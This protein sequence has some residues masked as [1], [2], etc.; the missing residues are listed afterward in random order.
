[1][2]KSIWTF[3][4]VFV[5]SVAARAQV[6]S[7]EEP[8]INI[9]N[10]LRMTD[11]AKQANIP[12]VIG[13]PYLFD[14]WNE[15]EMTTIGGAIIRDILL[16]YNCYSGQ[17][18]VIKKS[19]P[20]SLLVNQQFIREFRIFTDS[21]SPIIF[22][23]YQI[24]SVNNIE[25]FAFYEVLYEGGVNLVKLFSKKIKHYASETTLVA[26][27]KRPRLVSENELFLLKKRGEYI[28]VTK[29]NKKKIM[30]FFGPHEN[31]M[32]SYRKA[33]RLSLR[34]EEDLIQ[35]LSEYEAVQ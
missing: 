9:N 22:K 15:S 29:N 6:G 23:K 35:L 21:D 5:V 32:E 31:Q 17:I 3:I 27:D 26:A 4:A 25:E 16:K 28:S 11:A 19:G 14:E 20:D 7:M 1:M 34:S 30:A 18:I 2:N 8:Y 24:Q 12:N 10:A 33:N 13:T